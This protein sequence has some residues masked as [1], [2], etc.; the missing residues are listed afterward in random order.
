[1]NLRVF[2]A[3]A[4]LVLVGAGFFLWKTVALETPLLPSETRDLWQV[5]IGVAVRGD[6]EPGSVLLQLPQSRAGQRIFAEHFSGDRLTLSPRTRKDASV[7]VWSG[8]VD[9]IHQ[10]SYGFRARLFPARVRLPNQAIGTSKP[11]TPPEDPV[12]SGALEAGGVDLSALFEVIDLP[13]RSDFAG[14]VRSLFAFV[15]HEINP[16]A[17][18][19]EDPLLALDQREA[20]ALGKERLLVA[21]LRGTGLEARV[22]RGLE[23]GDGIPQQRPWSEVWTG[24]AWF[25]MSTT[26]GFFGELPPRYV[27]LSWNDAPPIKASGV[28][29]VARSF[30]AIQVPFTEAELAAL[31]LPAHPLVAKLSLYRLPVSVQAALRVL[32]LLP[33]GALA[34]ALLRNIVGLPS[35]GTFMPM[36]LALA[37]RGTGLEMGLLLVGLVLVVGV[38]GRLLLERF[39]LLLVPRLGLILCLVVLTVTALAITGRAFEQADLYAGGLFPMV[40]LTML[41]ERFSIKAAEEGLRSATTY[42][43]YSVAIAIFLFPI[44]RSVTIEYVMFGFPEL[45]FAV[46]GM[47]VW[48]GGYTGY[49][50]SDLIRFRLLVRDEVAT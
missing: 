14:R 16:S 48:V 22:V 15:S 28:L 25:P 5:E 9:G 43:A 46:M 7:A 17:T 1:M 42:A 33:V 6:G 38:V 21:L 35:Y 23:L 41:V 36:L 3:G 39:H 4:L 8:R 50:L 44:F 34:I 11:E 49:R 12:P 32:L 24:E 19:S 45:I 40:I 30:R 27:A 29:S 20:N 10:L 26:A 47:L 31:A 2:L 13:P 37:L 18:A